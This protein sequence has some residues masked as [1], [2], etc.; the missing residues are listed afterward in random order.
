M[1]KYIGDLNHYN[2]HN[3]SSSIKEMVE[4]II[5]NNMLSLDKVS[6]M[7]GVSRG[8]LLRYFSRGDDISYMRFSVVN[9]L[10][11]F[12]RFYLENNSSFQLMPE[13]SNIIN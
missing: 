13:E 7:T 6:L 12:I 3:Y 2:Y 9:K 1:I 5:R 11:N 10:N 8:T 4:E